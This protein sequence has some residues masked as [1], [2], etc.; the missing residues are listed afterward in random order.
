M[1]LSLGSVVTLLR[2]PHQSRGF[3]SGLGA[4]LSFGLVEFQYHARGYKRSAIGFVAAFAAS[5]FWTPL[6]TQTYTGFSLGYS[7]LRS[8]IGVLDW[9]WKSAPASPELA[10]LQGKLV[11]LQRD[12]RR[13]DEGEKAA[14]S[15]NIENLKKEI[16]GQTGVSANREV[17]TGTNQQTQLI[18]MNAVC[19]L[20]SGVFNCI[21]TPFAL[22]STAF[23]TEEFAQA[24]FGKS[25]VEVAAVCAGTA[26]KVGA[27]V[28]CGHFL[29]TVSNYVPAAA[30]TLRMIGEVKQNSRLFIKNIPYYTF[31]MGLFGVVSASQ[32]TNLALMSPLFLWGAYR[33][34]QDP[35]MDK[36]QF[37]RIVQEAVKD[38]S[39]PQETAVGM[40]VKLLQ[41]YVLPFLPW[42]WRAQQITTG[43]ERLTEVMHK[44]LAC[45]LFNHLS[46]AS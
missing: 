15:R 18:L 12:L 26:H 16:Q 44:G 29:K 41:G 10:R 17:I 19:D 22:V 21:T 43:L 33:L 11:A 35:Q 2:Q 38:P 37:A 40:G 4:V 8:R 30:L 36:A 23:T 45:S 32:T 46:K 27:L 42:Q 7:L 34:S 31:V 6:I 25:A 3:V 5:F 20:A 9:C 13:A 24:E 28:A 39:A 1:G 14:I